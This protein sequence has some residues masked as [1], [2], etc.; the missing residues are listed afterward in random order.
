MNNVNF[1]VDRN[2]L[3]SE[4]CLHSDDVWWTF[5]VSKFRKLVGRRNK[6]SLGSLVG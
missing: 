6:D 5:Q 1:C 3:E 2:A 4:I